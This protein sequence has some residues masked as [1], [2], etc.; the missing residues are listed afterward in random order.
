MKFGEKGWS[1]FTLLCGLN[2]LNNHG[3]NDG[4]FFLRKSIAHTWHWHAKPFLSWPT[5]CHYFQIVVILIRGKSSYNFP[6]HC[7]ESN[8]LDYKTIVAQFIRATHS[9]DEARTTF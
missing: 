3:L 6:I 7:R 8:G 9:S 4:Q 5:E 2:K 1:I